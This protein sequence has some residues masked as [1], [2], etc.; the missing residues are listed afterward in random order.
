MR[1]FDKRRARHAGSN[2]HEHVAIASG[3]TGRLDGD[4]LHFSF[5]SIGDHIDTLQ[6]FTSIGARELLSKGKSFNVTSPVTHSA[7]VFFKLYLLRLGFLD[8]FAG[9][10]VAVLSAAHVFTKYAKALTWRWQEQRGLRTKGRE[11]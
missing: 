7:W 6:R 8:G 1:L 10:S 5:D 11:A 3:S 9:L 4:L 2:P